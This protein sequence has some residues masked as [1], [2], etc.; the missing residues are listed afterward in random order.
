MAVMGGWLGG[1]V[2]G[3]L[4]V[5][6]GARDSHSNQTHATTTPTPTS[7]STP[8]LTPTPTPTPAYIIFSVGLIKPFQEAMFPKCFGS[9][10]ECS[11][12]EVR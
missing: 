9:H 5:G 3:V 8:T 11:Y 7:T 6:G 1:W 2:G 10:D 12:S 4:A